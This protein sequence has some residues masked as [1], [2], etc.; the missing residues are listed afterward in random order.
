M[1]ASMLR[2]LCVL[3][4]ALATGGCSSTRLVDVWSSPNA[5]TTLKFSRVVTV[6]LFKDE[7]SRRAGEDELVERIG[8]ERATPSYRIMSLEQARDKDAARAIIERGEY[9]GA[10]VMRLVS[11]ERQQTW[12]PGT[13]RPPGYS[14]SFY[15]YCSVGWS[16]AYEPGRYEVDTIVRIETVI[17]SLDGPD[18]MIWAAQS[19]T[20]N[21]TSVTRT[22][23]EIA[24]AVTARMKKDGLI[25]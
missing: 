10:V 12:V 25:D 6:C 18:E 14:S 11:V 23:K 24:D 9:D 1:E 19:E 3:A 16:Y 8:P 17:Y 15:D 20:F 22:V 7:I 13:P 21:P 4:C 2:T 5:P